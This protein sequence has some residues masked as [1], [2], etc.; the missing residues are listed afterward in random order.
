MGE[1]KTKTQYELARKYGVKRPT[2][3]NIVCG[4]TWKHLLEKEEMNR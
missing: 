2:I 1:R 4:R 3:S